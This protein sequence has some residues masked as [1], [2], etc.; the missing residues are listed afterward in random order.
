MHCYIKGLAV[1]ES[2]PRALRK[3][4]GPSVGKMLYYKPQNPGSPIAPLHSKPRNYEVKGIGSNMTRD[5]LLQI[6][7][8]E[9][10]RTCVA[11]FDANRRA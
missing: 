3:T 11:K 1:L 5:S 4:L 6:D 9:S 2:F 10:A 8:T 7:I